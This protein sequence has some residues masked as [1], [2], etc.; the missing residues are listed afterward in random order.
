MRVYASDH[1]LLELAL[2]RLIEDDESDR[3]ATFELLAAIDDL[4]RHWLVPL[5]V[6]ARIECFDFAAF[7]GRRAPAPHHFLRAASLHPELYVDIGYTAAR[8]TI[9]PAL[10]PTTRR[11]WVEAAL[12]QTCEA[13]REVAL[14]EVVWTIVRARVPA[15]PEVYYP[16]GEVAS[17]IEEH[18]GALWALGR[19]TPSPVGPPARVR[20]VNTH[21]GLELR[22]DVY[23][24]A[25]TVHP[26]GRALVERGV[27]RVL[28]RGRGWTRRQV[29]PHT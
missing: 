8:E 5:G 20:A 29:F 19:R 10:D 27:E 21:G 13:G 23:W 24:D 2:E 7:E 16:G 1:A 9:V 11:N 22:L 12:E 18:D 6:G 4:T 14:S 28:A 15:R 17:I 3:D 26:E 25:W